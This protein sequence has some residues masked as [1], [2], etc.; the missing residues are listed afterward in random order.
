MLHWS[1]AYN[2]PEMVQFFL[3]QKVN[4]NLISKVGKRREREMREMR[5]RDERDERER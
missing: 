3:S 1:V 5:E 2:Q 4:P